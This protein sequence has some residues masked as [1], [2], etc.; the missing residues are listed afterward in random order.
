M[1]S[2]TGAGPLARLALRRDR[3]RLPVW[4]V[5]IVLL[6]A[7]TPGSFAALFPTEQGLSLIHI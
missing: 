2:F 3:V 1:R 5:L 6:P 4:I 7:V